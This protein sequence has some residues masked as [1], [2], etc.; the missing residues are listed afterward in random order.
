MGKGS[1]QKQ[2]NGSALEFEAQ[3]WAA[4]DK[5][6]GHMDASEYKHV[7]LGLI[8]LKYISDAFEEKR[9]QL[10]LSFADPKSDWFIKDE[11]QR[12]EAADERDQYVAAN[13]FWVPPEARWHK[14]NAKAK[15][16]EIGKIIDDAMGAIE[17]ENPKLKGVLPRDYARPSLDKV[18]LGGLVDII[19]NIGFNQSAAK[20]KDVLGRVYEYFLG[21]FASAEG[22]G[23]G[24]FYTPQCVV[25]VLVEMLE[26]YKGRVYD[27]AC[28]SGGMFVSSEKFVEEHGGRIGDIAVYGQ[29]SNYTTWKL[30]RMNLAIRGIDANLG[31]RNAD[32][33]RSDLHPDLKA[34]FI[35]ANPPFNMS[36][37]GGEHLRQDVRWKFGMPP[38]S[39]ANFAWVQHFVHHL[40]PNGVAGFILGNI[41]LTSET[42]GE[43]AIRKGLVESDL[44]ECIITFPDKLFYST[45]IPAGIWILR[46]GRGTGMA[47]YK[48]KQEILFIEASRL[49]TDISRTHR[50]LADK[51]IA[52]ISQTYRR[53]LK[54]SDEYTDTLG[55]N[56]SVPIAEVIANNYNLLPAA[57][58]N[59]GHTKSAR[60]TGLVGVLKS[61]ERQ[62]ALSCLKQ[63]S[64]LA[65]AFQK[66]IGEV[67]AQ[68]KAIEKEI[69]FETRTLG[70]LLEPSDER[71]R[72]M[73]EPEV[74]TCTE[75][76]GLILQRERFAKRVA[77]DDASDYK[78]V[79][80]GDI[81]YNPYLLW[82]GSIDQ[83][84]IVEMG[85]TSPAYE[86]LRVRDGFDKTIVGQLVTSPEMIKRYDGIS[87]G[88]VQ[89]RR[90]APVSNFLELKVNVPSPKNLSALSKLL[91]CSQDCQFAS[92]NAERAIRQLIKTLCARLR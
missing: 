91:S 14:I 51:D 45:P 75:R 18:R 16:P 12:P 86:V 54:L 64:D 13:V 46:R 74:L 7:C 83:C 15:S 11:K 66:S 40:S 59:A 32:S 6:R 1:S 9:E 8:F 3:L 82:K 26:P 63:V 25:Q 72:E 84:W 22:K 80:M 57:Y 39:N 53:W 44:V 78:I 76:G 29:E 10:L 68:I 87:F 89:R 37:W 2:A 24:E 55:F 56:R 21:K 65:E 27:P 70:E 61:Q 20:S 19:S 41:S 5:M 17:R 43:D 60:S 47:K 42:G 88:T 31:P 92:R 71:L 4:A 50:E 52:T 69:A 33:F 81:V 28:G 58:V 48:R 35:L 49:G 62:V 34:D 77:T 38:V 23:G 85:I 67:D 90:R 73:D 36:D 30:A 79:R